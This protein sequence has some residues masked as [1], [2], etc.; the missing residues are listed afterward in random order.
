MSINI[1]NLNKNFGRNVIFDDFSYSFNN[2][3][4]YIIT[5]SS[6]RGK[7][8]LLRLISGLDK[9]F[10]GTIEGGGYNSVSVHFQEYRLFDSL[11]VLENITYVSGGQNSVDKETATG[12]LLS[13]GLS[14]DDLNKHINELSGGMKMRVS[15]ARA[16]LKES[17]VLL[18][19]EPLKELDLKSIEA[20]C[21]VI[22]QNAEK[23]LVILVTHKIYP[24]LFGEY[25]EIKLN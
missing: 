1:K 20:V 13:L 23:R 19:D 2:T 15:F 9:D 10:S 8:T 16:V 11:T 4:L 5:G 22:R 6:G 24:D 18:L 21:E 14:D 17:P 12:M 25:T 3:G 7:T